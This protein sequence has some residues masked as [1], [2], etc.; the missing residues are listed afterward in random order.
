MLRSASV[1][2]AVIFSFAFSS[3]ATAQA[4]PDA[5]Q[6]LRVFLE[7]GP[8]DFDFQRTEIGYVSWMRDRADADVHILWRGQPT[9]AGGSRHTLDFVGL[10]TFAGKAD[11]L[12][13]V[14]GR[15][16]TPDAVRRG[17][18]RVLEMGL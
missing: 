15:D 3:P 11:T 10:Q 16:D 4:A 1:L 5:S 12:V 17:L 18:N 14:Q 7:C 13:F 9:G 6:Q 2:F 8:C